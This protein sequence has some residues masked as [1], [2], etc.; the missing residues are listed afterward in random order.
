MRIA[1]GVAL[2]AEEIA[3]ATCGKTSGIALSKSVTH[4]A[5][6]SSEVMP[7]DLF[8]ALRGNRYSGEDFVREAISHGAIALSTKISDGIITV[9]NTESALLSLA[10]YYK[11]RLPNLLYTVGITGSVGKTTTKEFLKIIS[12]GKYKTHSTVGNFNNTI[13][14]PLTLLSAPHG[15]EVLI[16]EMGMNRR[17]EISAL[18]KCA[19]PDIGIIT[20]IGIAHIGRLGSRE[21]I[22]KA[23]L[24]ILDGMKGGPLI[25]PRDEPLLEKR[26]CDFDYSLTDT[27]AD[28]TVLKDSSDT[29]KLT[30]RFLDRSF[31]CRFVPFGNHLLNCLGPAIMAGVL[32][33]LSNDELI[34]RISLISHENTRQNIVLCKNFYILADYYNASYESVIADFEMISMMHGYSS[35]SALIGSILE[36]GEYAS[37]IHYRLGAQAARFGF[38]NLYF[39]GEY[40]EILKR[41][42]IDAGFSEDHIYT[43]SSES[44][45]ET[46]AEQ[47]YKSTKPGEIILF[48]ASRGIRL[49]G[50]YEILKDL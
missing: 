46:T 42:A 35:R 25:I 20:N 44:I 1:L 12:S 23:K 19:S 7:G 5:T 17:G 32:T 39:I 36:L 2:T 30:V 15:T 34:T 6:S 21:E 33:K 50:V 18:S 31:A 47:I 9:D 40:S 28:I 10:A 8:V 26:E 11:T 4:I 37:D 24:E 3:H 38:R 13:G 22:A 41:G 48:K 16:L 43:N 29:S 49:E 27:D 14:L 45:P